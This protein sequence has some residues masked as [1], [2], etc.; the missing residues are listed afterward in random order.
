MRTIHTLLFCSLLPILNFAQTRDKDPVV[1]RG[2]NLSCMVGIQPGQIVAFAFNGGWQQIPVQIDEI[3]LKDIADAYGSRNDC[4]ERSSENVE[5]MV[6]YYADTNTDV[7]PDNNALF[8]NNDELVFMAKDAGSRSTS[9]NCPNGVIASTKCEITVRD[10]LNNSIWGYVYVF[11]QTGSLNQSAGQNYV[12][13]NYSYANNYKSTYDVCVFNGTN[14]NPE[15][16]VVTTSEYSSEFSQ[17]WVEDVLKITAGNANG[18]D[19]LDAHQIFI[20]ASACNRNEQV[21]SDGKGPLVANKD[22]AVRAIRSVM[23]AKSGTFTQQT[24]KFTQYQAAY[25]IHY[26]LHTAN[27]YTD[28]FDFSSDATGM[29]YYSDRATG[30]VTINGNPDNINTDEPTKW[31]L[32]TGQQGSLVTTFEWDT[33]MSLGT[34]PQ[35]DSGSRE[36][37][38]SAYYSDKGSAADFSCTGD[39]R[40]YGS[41]GFSLDSKECT[42]RRAD[43]SD[44]PE[45]RGNSVRFFDEFRTHYYLPPNTTTGQAST[46]GNYGCNP[47]TTSSQAMSDCNGGGGNPTCDD[48]IQN[49]DEEGVDCGGS[50]C[51]PCMM[52]PTCDDGIQN[53]DEEGVD[54]GGSD[55]A[56]CMMEPTCDDGIQNGDEEGVDCGGSDCPPCMMEPTCDDG[57]QNGDEEG[58]DCGGSNCPPCMTAPT[59]DDGI[60]NGLETG[61]DCGGPDCPPCMMETCDA[62]TGLF[63]TNNTGSQVTLNWSA[64]DNADSYMVQGRQAGTSAWRLNQNS[65]TNS[66]TI[67]RN[68]VNGLTYEW[69]VRANCGSEDSPYSE[70]ATFTAG[71]NGGEPT[72]DDGIQNGDEEGVDCGGSNCPPCMTD[73]TCDDGIQNGDEEGVDCGG[74]DCPPCMMEPTCDDGIQNGDEEGVDCGGS[75]CPPCMMETCE[76]PTNLVTNN[77]QDRQADLSWSAVD[78]AN[79]YTVQLRPAGRT[80]WNTRTSPTNSGV[81]Q[82]L[83]RN[84]NYEWR[85][86]ANCDDASSEYS[87]IATFTTANSRVEERS[88]EIITDAPLTAV[89]YPS[90]AKE[91]VQVQSNKYIDEIKVIDITGRLVLAEIRLDG[92]QANLNIANLVEGHYFLQIQ[93]EGAVKTLRFVKQ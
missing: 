37:Y 24:I 35:F 10:P 4:I 72:C 20:N 13:Y 74:S 43:F 29:T 47:L 3:V 62:P 52:E 78:G 90:P 71:D 76:T 38:L 31:E 16:S 11:Q 25:T 84:T 28:V 33:D 5:W 75:D 27:G 36:A 64:V 9:N 46:Y 68:I 8:D 81:A 69:R 86:R 48:G 65:N 55:C 58:V 87:E 39:G 79:N 40:S 14:N 89:V 50:D 30:G 63:E 77:I 12:S 6:E 60:Q 70:I 26:R 22:G 67:T 21:F 59:C 82:P 66:T 80:N 92:K 41:C 49:G 32:I 19:I 23:G 73:P 93:A 44:Y 83:R 61:V 54:C 2:N 17:R 53:G 85:V 57:I 18:K 56:P 42:D 34:K 51:P 88:E 91:T 1:I 15:K 45:C 7:G